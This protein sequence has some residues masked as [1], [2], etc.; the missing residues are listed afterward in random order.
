[1]TNFFA[2]YMTKSLLLSGQ[3]KY[4][5]KNCRK[6]EA[7]SLLQTPFDYLHKEFIKKINKMVQGEMLKDHR[8]NLND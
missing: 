4:L 5:T 8:F 7:N 1:M 3:P 2:V 6:S